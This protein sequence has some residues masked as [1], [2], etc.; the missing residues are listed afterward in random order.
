MQSLACVFVTQDSDSRR[1]EG[2]LTNAKVYIH[3]TVRVMVC[4]LDRD[5]FTI[6]YP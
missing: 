1:Q 2:L 6:I 5:V 3:V 4:H